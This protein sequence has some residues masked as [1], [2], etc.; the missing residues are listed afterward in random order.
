LAIG[1]GNRVLMMQY[2]IYSVITPEGCASI[3]FRNAARADWAAEALKLV[4]S[5]LK[6][7]GV[8]DEVIAE[9]D[10]GAHRDPAAAA[11]SLGTALRKHL[12]ELS[13]LKPD[14]LI[15][16]RYDKFRALGVFS[17]K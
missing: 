7:F 11:Q 4:A 6:Q 8:V 10:G 16:Q 15:A 3:L 2:S 1:V 14:Q 12:R 13:K 17:G 5:D 9:P